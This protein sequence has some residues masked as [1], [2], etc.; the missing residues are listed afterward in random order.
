VSGHDLDKPLFRG[1]MHRVAFFVSIPAGLALIFAADSTVAR[2]AAAIYA[3]SLAGLFGASAAY[4]TVSWSEKNLERM[5]AL[6]HSM[7]FVLIAG[8]YTPFLLI[9]VEGFWAHVLLVVVWAGALLGIALKIIHVH[10]FRVISGTLYIT[11]GWVGIVTLPKMLENLPPWEVGLV[12]AGAIIY[13]GGA[14]ILLRRKPD[15]NPKVFGYHEVWHTAV[16]LGCACFY[17]VTLFVVAGN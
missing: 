14:V 17:I 5:K 6:D 12:L 4:H 11:L 7:I 13:T 16:V 15:P 1:Q 3:I 2:L 9:V 10:G 8:T